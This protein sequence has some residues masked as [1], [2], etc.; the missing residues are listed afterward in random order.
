MRRLCRVASSHVDAPRRARVLAAVAMCVW[1]PAVGTAAELTRG[2]L[3]YT[4]D[5]LNSDL[6]NDTVE[7]LGNVRL[8]QDAMSIESAQ[9]RVAASGSDNSRWLFERSVRLR[10]AEADLK[11]DTARA[12]FVDGQIST[13]RI[14][15]APAEFE[16]RGGPPDRQ[17]RGRAAT[18]DYDFGRGVVTLTGDVWFSYGKDE[19]RCE[20]V[21]Y[22]IRDE[23]VNC[24]SGDA[25]P[26]RVRGTIRPRQRAQTD[27]APGSQ[28]PQLSSGNGA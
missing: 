20:T 3:N 10:T 2:P 1:L 9:A 28:A 15:G 11:A 24:T 16:Q 8:T 22:S 13:A 17:V 5:V 27:S 4:A 25:G 14:E 23:R 26:G 21:V 6:R 18:I 12:A 7:L 19:F